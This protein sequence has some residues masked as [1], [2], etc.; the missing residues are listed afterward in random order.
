MA[1]RFPHMQVDGGDVMG[2]TVSSE[3]K[4]RDDSDEGSPEPV[5]KRDPEQDWTAAEERRLV[6]KVSSK[7]PDVLFQG[8]VVPLQEYHVAS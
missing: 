8:V 6:F 2:K 1:A 3:N 4:M 7:T 5:A